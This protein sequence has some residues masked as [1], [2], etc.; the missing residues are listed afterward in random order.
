[1]P[2]GVDHRAV[3]ERVRVGHAQLDHVGARLHARL[4][5]PRPTR[6]ASGSRP[7]GTASARRAC[8]VGERRRRSARSPL[9]SR[10]LTR[11]PRRAPRRDPCRR[12]RTG[13]PGRARRRRCAST[14][15]SACAVSSAGMM[16]SRR[17]TSRNAASASRVGHR[18]VARA[19]AVA[20]VRVLRARRRGSRGR[21]RSSA[22]RRSAPPRP[23]SPPSA[24]RAGCPA[25]PP[26]VSGAPWRGV[27]MPSP[28]G[29]DA[30]QLDL[31]RRR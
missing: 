25:R 4:A 23:A 13:T 11:S 27:S 24:S 19:A 22:P 1:M 18:H 31:A 14:H 28:A 3:G 20:Q 6:R 30:D 15:A 29:L 21:P 12:G 9:A 7:S 2:G 8:R 16:P 10:V 5:D 17:A 26:T